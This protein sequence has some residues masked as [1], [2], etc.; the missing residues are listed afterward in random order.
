MDVAVEVCEGEGDLR[1]RGH[2]RDAEFR[3]GSPRLAAGD[4]HL[5][6]D[7]VKTQNTE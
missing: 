4:C 1:G 7:L 5:Q 2:Q 6:G 3:H